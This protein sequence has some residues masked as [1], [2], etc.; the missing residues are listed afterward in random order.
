MF[1]KTFKSEK[2]IM[3]PVVK[4]SI[5]NFLCMYDELLLFLHMP[6]LEG[7]SFQKVVS[8]I[9]LILG[10]TYSDMQI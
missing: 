5:F 8:I 4:K 3:L 7:C 2:E 10:V 1:F 9:L 6:A